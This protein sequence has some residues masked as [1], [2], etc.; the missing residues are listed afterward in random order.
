M[1]ADSG[2]PI[3]EVEGIRR[4]FGGLQ[5]VDG[6]SFSI[7]RGALAAVIGPNG[8]GKST[9]INIISGAI[10]SQRGRVRFDGTDITG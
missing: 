8:A 10:S 5:A 1:P 2:P 6:C 3:L 9:V 4:S 7:A